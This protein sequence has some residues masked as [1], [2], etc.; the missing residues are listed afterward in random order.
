MDKRPEARVPNTRHYGVGSDAGGQRAA[1]IYTLIETCK[2][3]DLDPRAWLTD[4]LARLATHPASKIDKLMPWH[5]AAAQVAA[6]LA[7]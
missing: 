6:K 2:L 4:V 7:A 3:N 1:A 5:W